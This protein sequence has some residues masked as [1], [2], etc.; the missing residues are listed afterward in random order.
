[1][2][3]YFKESFRRKKAR[4]V[5]MEYPHRIDKFNLEREG[6]IEFAN[7]ENPLLS[8]V[9]IT[10]SEIDFYR[11]FIKKGDFIIDI[12]S[13]TGDTTVPMAIAAGKEGLTLAFDPNPMVFKILEVNTTLNKDKTNIVPVLNAISVEEEEFYF[14]SSEASFS[15][16]GIS[17]TKESSLGKYVYPHKIKGVNLVSFLNEN[18]AKALDKLSF[19][20]VDAEGYDKEIIKSISDLIS[21][22]KPCIIAESFGKSSDEAKKE[23]FE[24]ISIH[25]YKLFYFEDFLSEAKTKEINSAGEMINWKDTINIYALPN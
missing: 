2:I 8:P 1:M 20:K 3:K 19:I 16:G 18:H 7:W 22:Y 13:N 14:I 11:K 4:R 23:L 12:G 17:P 6:E 24:V 10:Q 5:T 15:N 25:D 21:K 9:R